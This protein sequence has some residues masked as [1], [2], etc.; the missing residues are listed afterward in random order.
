MSDRK[1]SKMKLLQDFELTGLIVLL[2]GSEKED[3]ELYRITLRFTHTGD[4]DWDFRDKQEAE[5]N[6]LSVCEAAIKLSLV[7]KRE[8]DQVI[9]MRN[10]K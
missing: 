4:I 8:T 9:K 5:D 3:L 10:N 6:Y 1:E 7:T 2:E